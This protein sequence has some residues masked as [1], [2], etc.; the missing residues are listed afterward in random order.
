MEQEIIEGQE[1]VE[2]PT[3]APGDETP[4]IDA[5]IEGEPAPSGDD[6][7]AEPD[8]KHG[9]QKRIDELTKFGREKERGEAYWKGMYDAS[10]AGKNTPQTE[11]V[12]PEQPVVSAGI[13]AESDYDTTEEYKV[14]MG[15]Y[16]QSQVNTGVQQGNQQT[17]QANKNAARIQKMQ[18]AAATRPEVME[19]NYAALP[20]TETML[21]AADGDNF[22]DIIYEISKNPAEAQRIANLPLGQQ[23]KEIMRVE[24]RLTAK[25]PQKTKTDAPDPPENDI[26]PG[27]GSPQP[28]K[29][30][31]MTTKEQLAKWDNEERIRRG[32][33]TI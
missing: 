9:V 13:P 19:P 18:D 7:T 32:I 17:T 5:A 4:A 6:S 23:G 28:K 30:E 27:V 2:T 10:E 25:P 1:P 26:G 12:T 31:D 20:L 33:P 11:V 29:L 24:T 16:I 21:E 15:A 8:K 22:V 3:D 14:A